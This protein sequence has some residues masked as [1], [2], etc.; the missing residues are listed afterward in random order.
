MTV[1]LIILDVLT[2]FSACSRAAWLGPWWHT[3]PSGD[4]ACQGSGPSISEQ[5]RPHQPW[6]K[7]KD[8]LVVVPRATAG[9]GYLSGR[10]RARWAFHH[11]PEG[12]G[13]ALNTCPPVP[14]QVPRTSHQGG[15]D[16]ALLQ[17]VSGVTDA[18]APT[19]FLG[20]LRHQ[21]SLPQEAR[22]RG[23]TQ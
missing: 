4:T 9:P 1:I 11:L 20:P 12:R 13:E 7:L 21:S 19:P 22:S 2:Q 23:A 3:S 10:S 14:P 5:T 15:R 17:G 8:M 16:P 6:R 18:V